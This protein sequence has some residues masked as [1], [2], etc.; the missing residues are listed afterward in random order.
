MKNDDNIKVVS[1]DINDKGLTTS[2]IE[3]N[4]N[5]LIAGYIIVVGGLVIGWSI[6]GIRK[7]RRE[8]TKEVED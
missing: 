6:A 1:T 7:W 5:R 2:E 4:A 3:K 8:R